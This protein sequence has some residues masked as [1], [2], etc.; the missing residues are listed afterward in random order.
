MEDLPTL[1]FGRSPLFD[2]AFS[3]FAPLNCVIDL[4]PTACGL[5]RLLKPGATAMLVIFGTCCPGEVVVELFRGRP[6]QTLRRWK[7]GAVAARLAKREFSV[8]YHRRADV[9]RAFAPWF[10]L[11]K[12]DWHRRNCASQCCGAVDFAPSAFARGNGRNRPCSR[13]SSGGAGRSRAL[14][15]RRTPQEVI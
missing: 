8:V 13:Q 2:G 12:A 3:N 4:R 14:S 11:E 15:A 10:V 7:R 6:N 9:V 1:S 5:A